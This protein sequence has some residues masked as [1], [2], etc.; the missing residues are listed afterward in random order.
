MLFDELLALVDRVEPPLGEVLQPAERGV[1]H[2]AAVAFLGVIG[3]AQATAAVGQLELDPARFVARDRTAVDL[4]VDVV[5][6]SVFGGG[7]QVVGD[8]DPVNRRRRKTFD[9]TGGR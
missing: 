4:Q 6:Q 9:Q 5:R 7:K 8:I 2:D 1:G 3:S